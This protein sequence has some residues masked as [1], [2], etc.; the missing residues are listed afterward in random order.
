MPITIR[1][2]N[3]HP[4]KKQGAQIQLRTLFPVLCRS[5]FV[6]ESVVFADTCPVVFCQ[7]TVL[8]VN[9]ETLDITRSP[10]R[11]ERQNVAVPFFILAVFTMAV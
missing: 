8:M 3:L 9:S 5:I 6:T 1:S 10:C 7:R 2:D 11:T 4:T